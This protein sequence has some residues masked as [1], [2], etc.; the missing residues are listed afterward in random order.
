MYVIVKPGAGGD[1][2][3]DQADSILSAI[4]KSLVKSDTKFELED[5]STLNVRGRL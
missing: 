1:N 3:K 2:T 4:M 5:D